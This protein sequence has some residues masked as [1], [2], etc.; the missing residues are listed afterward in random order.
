MLKR[1]WELKNAYIRLSCAGGVHNVLVH[2]YKHKKTG[3]EK[4]I[5]KEW[6]K[7]NENQ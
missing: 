6:K 7:K 3:K 1:N 4:R 2:I 5:E